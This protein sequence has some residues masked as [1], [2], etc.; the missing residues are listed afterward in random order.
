MR[1]QTWQSV[2]FLMAENL[3]LLELVMKN[4]TSSWWMCEHTHCVQ[5]CWGIRNSIM[6]IVSLQGSDWNWGYHTYIKQERWDRKQSTALLVSRECWEME[7]RRLWSITENFL[8]GCGS[9]WVVM[10]H[11]AGKENSRGHFCVRPP[12]GIGRTWRGIYREIG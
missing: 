12:K 7:K 1:S 6:R 2:V 5:I 4:R 11:R 8:E 9:I 10:V 3:M